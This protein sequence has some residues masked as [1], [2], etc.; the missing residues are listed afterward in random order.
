M[1][2]RYI[3]GNLDS[4]RLARYKSKNIFLHLARSILET[5]ISSRADRRTYEKEVRF[6]MHARQKAYSRHILQRCGLDHRM[7]LKPRKQTT[8]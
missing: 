7:T 3:E 4:L 6:L 2:N 5:I 8:T 1:V